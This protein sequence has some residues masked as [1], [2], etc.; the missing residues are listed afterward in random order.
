MARIEGS[1]RELTAAALLAALT[2]ATAIVSIP[3]GPVPVTLQ[4]LFVMLAALMLRPIW[5]AMSM[6]VYV[7]MGA[8]GLPVYAGLTGGFGHLIGPSGGYL[9]GFVAAAAI[10]SWSR[11]QLERRG[12]N[13][14]LADIAAIIVVVAVVYGLGVTQL[15]IVT[16]V[17][18]AG[19]SPI[20]AFAVGALPFLPGEAIKAVIAIAVAEAL[21]RTGVLPERRASADA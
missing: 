9:F 19:L 20:Q 7:L 15:V 17:G 3:M 21:R 16:T 11:I 18:G 5:A 4:M 8:V 13:Q 2:A 10:G 1:T 12:T 14:I 6:G